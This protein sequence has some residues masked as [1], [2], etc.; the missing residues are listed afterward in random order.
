[1]NTLIICESVH[2]GNTQKVAR[3]MAGVLKADVIRPCYVDLGTLEKYDLIGFG[4]GIYFARH[5]GE[6]FKLIEKIDNLNK[7]VFVFSTAAMMLTPL[8]HGAIRKALKKADCEVVGEFCCKG[9]D[10]F[11]ILKPIGGIHKGRP[12]E[13]DIENARDFAKA[14]LN[15][16]FSTK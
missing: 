12:N 13:E 15:A 3:A 10:D 2:K 5:H 11:G 6:I 7:K 16:D 1:M 4:S 8:F 14:L 9:F